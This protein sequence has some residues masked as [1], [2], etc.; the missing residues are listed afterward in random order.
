[1]VHGVTRR[2]GGDPGVLLCVKFRPRFE[3]SK[4]PP[5]TR[6]QDFILTHCI[7]YLCTI[8]DQ[9][10]HDGG[11]QS[12]FCMRMYRNGKHYRGCG[13]RSIIY[14]YKVEIY[15]ILISKMLQ[16]FEVSLSDMNL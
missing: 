3:I 4:C 1:M 2:N 8:K 14:E 15:F 11:T 10:C 5:K 9:N 16:Y 12:H 6:T 7:H 13:I